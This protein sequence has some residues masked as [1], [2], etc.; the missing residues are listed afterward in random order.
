MTLTIEVTPEVKDK[1]Q[2]KARSHGQALEE[3]LQDLLE[4][5]V[6]ELSAAEQAE[7]DRQDVADI[8]RIMVGTDPTQWRTL[9]ELRAHIEAARG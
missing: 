7:Q 8:E 9:D 3:Y 6:E 2:E 5:D 1:L 4:R